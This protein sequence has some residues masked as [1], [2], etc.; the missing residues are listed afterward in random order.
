MRYYTPLRYPGGKAK[1][2]PLIQNLLATNNLRG[3]AYIEPFAGG[4]AVALELLMK[5]AVRQVFVNDAD[6]AIYSLWTSIIRYPEAFAKRISS[7]PLTIDE[8]RNQRHMLD[9]GTEAGHFDL[10]FAAFYL[11]RVNRSGIL[12]GGPIG[13][14]EQAGTWRLDARFNRPALIERIKNV[15]RYANKINVSCDDAEAFLTAG[16][17]PSRA[18]C[19]IDPPY[20]RKGQRL[21][22]NH[23]NHDDHES[24]SHV[25]QRQLRSPWLVS[26]DDAPEIAQM[27]QNRRQNHLSLRYTAQVKRVADELMVYSDELRLPLLASNAA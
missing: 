2:T 10:G 3:G 6:P 7:I 1:L 22:R 19:Y 5:G 18:F 24:L 17:W 20:Y 21:Y 26:Y 25:V 13:G 12:K 9:S 15:S 8:W 16:D 14:Y 23:Y 4:A 27:Y 11:N